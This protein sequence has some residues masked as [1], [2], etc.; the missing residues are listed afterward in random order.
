[1]AMKIRGRLHS[2][3]SQGR[4]PGGRGTHVGSRRIR[5]HEKR[6]NIPGTES[7]LHNGLEVRSLMPL[8]PEVALT[9]MIGTEREARREEPTEDK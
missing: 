2:R 5:R 1:M 6:K 7:W 8:E 4:L 3:E 9:H